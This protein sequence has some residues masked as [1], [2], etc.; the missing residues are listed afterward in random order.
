MSI[1]FSGEH[2]STYTVSAV[3]EGIEFKK[4]RQGHPVKN[5][6]ASYQKVRLVLHSVK[7]FTRLVLHSVGTFNRAVLPIFLFD[8]GVFYKGSRR[9]FITVSV[10][11]FKNLPKNLLKFTLMQPHQM[12]KAPSHFKTIS[13][14]D[15]CY[16]QTLLY[17]DYL[18]T[19]HSVLIEE[20]FRSPRTPKGSERQ[21]K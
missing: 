6:K 16:L 20:D 12:A 13:S 14:P 18:G 17:H 10:I 4:V 9:Q 5:A 21:C 19:I 11:R 1:Y 3:K 15:L 2:N 8:L 7:H